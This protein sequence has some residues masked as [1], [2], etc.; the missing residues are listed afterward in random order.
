MSEYI[1]KSLV[2]CKKLTKNERIIL[3]RISNNKDLPTTMSNLKS[4]TGL[5]RRKIT[6]IIRGLRQYYP[7]CSTKVPPGGYWFG[8]KE[9]IRQLVMQLHCE[10]NTLTKTAGY[11]TVFMDSGD[12]LNEHF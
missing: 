5:N 6:D 7:I 4:A 3:S 10:I 1:K 9:D 2:T 8:D 12:T 11:L